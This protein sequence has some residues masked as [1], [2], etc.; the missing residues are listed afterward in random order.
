[1]ADSA[2]AKYSR[3]VVER[4]TCP[5]CAA[6]YEYDRLLETERTVAPGEEAAAAQVA[7]V[8]LARQQA[9]SPVAVV[10]CPTC[11]KFAPGAHANRL[12]MVGST[13]GGA[14]LC[15]LAAVGL[16]MLADATGRL[17][18]VLA[19]LAGLAVPAFLLMALFALLSPT[20]HKTRLAGAHGG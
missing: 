18:W 9:Q 19:L 2:K 15:A 11:R 8:E 1:M 14:A 20:T 6:V 4:V 5:R 12:M 3:T 10:R 17:F 16:L 13:L 7:E